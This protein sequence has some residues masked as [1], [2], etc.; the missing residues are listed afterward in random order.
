MVR[1]SKLLISDQRSRLDTPSK[2][3]AEIG[4]EPL[5]RVE[6]EDAH[7]VEALESDREQSLR[8][9][10]T[11]AVVLQESPTAFLPVA[12]AHFT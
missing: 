1:F 4:E 6:A 11:L 2:D 3:G 10:D 5:G 8:H 7:D 9:R 12:L